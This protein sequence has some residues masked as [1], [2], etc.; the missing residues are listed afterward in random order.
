MG[1]FG[2]NLGSFLYDRTFSHSEDIVQYFLQ[3]TKP[4][5]FPGK[6]ITQSTVLTTA[7]AV[8]R[9][10]YQA[11]AEKGE[12]YGL[13]WHMTGITVMAAC[14]REQTAVAARA[15]YGMVWW[16]VKRE[17]MRPARKRKPGCEEGPGW[18]QR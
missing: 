6:S 3:Q 14:T 9:G 8:F 13:S 1:S 16:I 4:E 15:T 12:V 11:G 17:T 2:H 18:P 10:I 5:Y 7:R